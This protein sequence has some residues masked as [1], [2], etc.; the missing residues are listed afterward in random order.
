MTE[1]GGS[2]LRGEQGTVPLEKLDINVM[3]NIDMCPC[4]AGVSTFGT[5]VHGREEVKKEHAVRWLSSLTLIR[6]TK[7]FWTVND[8]TK[9]PWIFWPHLTP[10]PRPREGSLTSCLQIRFDNAWCLN[11]CKVKCIS[12][13]TLYHSNHF[14]H[15][16]PMQ[17]QVLADTS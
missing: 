8:I 9:C 7:D 1:S 5:P 14:A 17:T 13:Y 4:A 3:S 12:N 10:L 6:F 11:L 15:R 16:L 2:A